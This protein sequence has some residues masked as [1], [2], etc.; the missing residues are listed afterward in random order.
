MKYTHTR[1]DAQEGRKYTKNKCWEEGMNEYEKQKVLFFHPVFVF[2]F[3]SHH[4]KVLLETAADT[5]GL[6]R[7]DE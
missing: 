6:E 5:R 3:L 7:G 2:V 1:R 4:H